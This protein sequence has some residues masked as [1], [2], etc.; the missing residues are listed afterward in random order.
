MWG[1]GAIRVRGNQPTFPVLD[2]WKMK[3]C[4]GGCCDGLWDLKLC[5]YSFCIPILQYWIVAFFD[6]W[7]YDVRAHFLTT[8]LF[9]SHT[10]LGSATVATAALS[11]HELLKIWGFVGA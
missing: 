11:A 9:V 1:I 3:I 7:I 5:I 6:P 8:E 10:V 2:L 4:V